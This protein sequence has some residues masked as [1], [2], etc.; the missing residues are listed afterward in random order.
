[1][2]LELFSPDSLFSPIQS[3][4]NF[5]TMKAYRA[6]QRDKYTKV[7]GRN[8]DFPNDYRREFQ[9]MTEK[10]DLARSNLEGAVN[11]C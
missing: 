6:Y 3:R 9:A 7:T 10:V 5:P 2:N 11:T 4:S 1:M 8:L